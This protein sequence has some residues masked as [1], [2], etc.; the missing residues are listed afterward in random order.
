MLGAIAAIFVPLVSEAAEQ[1][2]ALAKRVPIALKDD[3]ITMLPLPYWLE[4]LR[5]RL[6]Y[7][8]HEGL[9]SLDAKLVPILRDIGSN[10][11]GLVGGVVAAILIPILSF[12]FLQDSHA[13]KTAIVDIVPGEHRGVAEEIIQDLH[14]L[15]VQYIRALVL[16]ALL[17]FV[18]YTIFLYISGVSYPVLLATVAAFLEVIPI[19]GPLAAALVILLVGLLTGYPHLWLLVAFLIIFRIVQDYVVNPHLMSAGMAIHPLMV[20]FGVLAGEQIAGIPG[21]FFSVPVIA[22]LRIVV[23]QMRRRNLKPEEPVNVVI[24]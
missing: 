23:V 8:F 16:L 3:P 4:P 14:V 13:I 20:L 15:L 21:M 10:M 12:F 7:A 22:A 1:A 18:T 2:S 19:A 6:T 17:V 24:E 11:E 9:Y 5:D